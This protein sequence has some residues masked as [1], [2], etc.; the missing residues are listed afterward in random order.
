MRQLLIA[1]GNKGKQAEMRALFAD[2]PLKLI[3][4]DDISLS[5]DVAETGSTYQENAEIKARAHSAA[6]GLPSLA[7]DSGLEVDA[8]S[9][10]PG[11]RS[12]R[13]L[14]KPNATDRDRRIALIEKL[15]PFEQPWLA[16]FKCCMALA[17]QERQFHFSQGICEGE[18]TAEERGD[19][20]FGYDPIFLCENTG[21]TMAELGMIEKN[22]ISHRA[23]AAAGMRKIIF[24]L[25]K[26]D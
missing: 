9:G 2:L 26:A 23:R 18:I 24:G 10:A 19:N 5:L 6:S 22:R 17:V 3:F 20:G 15:R 12:A 1:T 16:R 25:L 8:L 4:P 7:D 13:F 14:R 21:K 11:L